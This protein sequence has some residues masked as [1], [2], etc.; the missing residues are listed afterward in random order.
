MEKKLRCHQEQ[1][2][3]IVKTHLMR[4]TISTQPGSK[5]RTRMNGC[6][7]DWMERGTE[8]VPT[9]DESRC[10]VQFL[11]ESRSSSL[12]QAVANCI[13]LCLGSSECFTKNGNHRSLIKMPELP[14]EPSTTAITS[15]EYTELTRTSL[16]SIEKRL[17]GLLLSSARSPPVK[18]LLMLKRCPTRSFS[19]AVLIKNLYD[20]SE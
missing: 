12:Q 15:C 19:L 14:G 16:A 9:V 4:E 6:V 1:E 18:G 11:V 8:G 3:H 2:S 7:V 10:E 20:L 13:Y 5:T 17:K